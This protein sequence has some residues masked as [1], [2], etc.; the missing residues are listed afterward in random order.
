M[1]QQTAVF[2]AFLRPN[3]ATEC[4]QALWN[5][6][7]IWLSNSA[8]RKSQVRSSLKVFGWDAVNYMF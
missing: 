7:C 6:R 2:F 1:F 3:V 5:K 8:V 4:W